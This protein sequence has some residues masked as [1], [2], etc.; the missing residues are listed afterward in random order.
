MKTRTDNSLKTNR[1]DVADM[2]PENFTALRDS[3]YK[4]SEALMSLADCDLNPVDR[5][6][7]R[8]ILATFDRSLGHLGAIL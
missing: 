5:E 3:Y 8:R 6:Q 1:Q 2:S 7:A 4:A